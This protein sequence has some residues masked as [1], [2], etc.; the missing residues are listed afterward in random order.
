MTVFLLLLLVPQFAQTATG[1]LRIQVTDAAQLPVPAAVV[2]V[3]EANQVREQFQADATGTLVARRL[4]FGVY[5][6]T[7][8]SAGFAPFTDT[9]DIRSALPRTYHVTLTIAQ[10]QANVTVSAGDTLLDPRRTTSNQRIGAET[11]RTRPAALP[12][13]SLPDLVDTQ[14][15]WLLEAN[16]VLHPRGSE[17]QTQYVVD[18]LPAHRQP[19]AGLRA[20][21]GC[22][23]GAR[24]EHPHRRVSR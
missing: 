12:G 2:L 10:V 21:T 5:R 18:G 16:G 4:P 14:P 24:V 17:Y 11:I 3:S 9:I 15:G 20:G 1:E 19:V 8:S 7:V 23:R 22:Q 6:V 13:R